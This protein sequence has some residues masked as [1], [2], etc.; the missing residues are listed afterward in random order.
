MVD[1]ADLM[2]ANSLSEAKDGLQRAL[3]ALTDGRP[4]DSLTIAGQ[5]VP[6]STVE[7][8]PQMADAIKGIIEGRMQEMDEELRRLGVDTGTEPAQPQAAPPPQQQRTPPPQRTPPR[9]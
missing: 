3:D 4:I 7:F 8:P 6:T 5:V 9:R 2:R 1:R